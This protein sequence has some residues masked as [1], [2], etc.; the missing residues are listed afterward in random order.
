MELSGKLAQ[1][2]T[3][4]TCT[5]DVPGS[6]LGRDTYYSEF[7]VVLFSPS[8]DIITSNLA[9][10]ASFHILSYSLFTN[11]VQVYLLNEPG[12]VRPSLW[13]STQR[14]RVHYKIPSLLHILSQINHVACPHSPIL[15]L[16]DPF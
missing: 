15:F 9:T 5:L 16:K 13:S 1:A 14:Y 3:L 7:F 10:T 4:L 8:T 11:H 2:I 6:N 12:N